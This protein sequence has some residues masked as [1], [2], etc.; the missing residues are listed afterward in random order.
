MARFAARRASIPYA[1]A[2]PPHSSTIAW[3]GL[4]ALI[5]G[6]SGRTVRSEIRKRRKSRRL[7]QWAIQDSNLKPTD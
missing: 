4:A 5:A 6:C 7:I 3:F 1:G 2:L